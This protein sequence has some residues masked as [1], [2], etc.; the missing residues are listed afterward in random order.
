VIEIDLRVEVRHAHD[1][2][3]ESK[4]GAPAHTT[5]GG[6]ARKGG[7]PVTARLVL[8]TD[9][10]NPSASNPYGSSSG[11]IRDPQRISAISASILVPTR[12][13]GCEGKVK[14]RGCRESAACGCDAASGHSRCIYV[15]LLNAWYSKI[16]SRSEVEV[17]KWR[18]WRGRK[19]SSKRA[20][21]RDAK[22]QLGS[23]EAAWDETRPRSICIALAHVVM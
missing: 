4:R 3:L 2:R 9:I 22:G 21:R 19:S 23:P 14:D 16:I 20:S 10:R 17:R 5:P 11:F 7:D 12:S 8:S 13:R 6:K 1:Q 18:Y 15:L